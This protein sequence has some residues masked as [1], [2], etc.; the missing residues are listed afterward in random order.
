MSGTGDKAEGA[1]DKTKGKVKEAVGGL[2]DNERLEREGK[3]DQAEGAVEKVKGHL[4]DAV[5]DVKDGVDNLRS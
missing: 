4:K 5:D 1:M 3:K 2:T